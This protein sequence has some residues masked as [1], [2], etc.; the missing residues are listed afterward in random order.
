MSVIIQ[1]QGREAIPVRALPLLTN[2]R[3]MAPD[4]AAHVLGGTG[5]NVDIFV[6]KFVAESGDFQALRFAGGVPEKISKSEWGDVLLELQSL[7]DTTKAT[8]PIEVAGY[9]AWKK[10]SPGL[11]P[12]GA[13]VWKDDYQRLHDENWN[14]RCRFL[15]CALEGG[16]DETDDEDEPRKVVD[17]DAL[18]KELTRVKQEKARDKLEGDGPLMHNIRESLVKLMRWKVPDYSPFM[19]ADLQQL[20][21]EGFDN[22]PSDAIPMAM[23]VTA[24]T[25]TTATPVLVTGNVEPASNVLSQALSRNRGFV[26]KKKA[27]IKKHEGDWPTI[28]RDFQDASTNGLSTVA[29]ATKYGDW[30]VE[31]A[32]NWARQRG[33]LSEA[34]EQPTTIK[35][36]LF[37]TSAHRI[38]G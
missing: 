8:E 25:Q 34:I 33:K 21:L 12:A 24:P 27:L 2:W 35:G 15:V 23:D 4:V 16:A 30:F 32:L 6:T 9:L 3:F 1:I 29:K 20:V 19:N 17:E 7:A 11:L 5:G 26:M 38:K 18:P 13:F 10:Q 22:L 37:P 14:R 36:T 31:D 28:N